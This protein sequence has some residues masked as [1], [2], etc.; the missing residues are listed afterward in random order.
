[1]TENH[2][3]DINGD[4]I[5]IQQNKRL[6]WLDICL[7]VCPMWTIKKIKR[8]CC[9][10]FVMILVI[11]IVNVGSFVYNFYRNYQHY[12]NVLFTIW[13]YAEGFMIVITSMVTLY[14]YVFVYKKY[15]DIEYIRKFQELNVVSVNGFRYNCVYC[16]VTVFL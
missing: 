6:I 10:D 15:Y 1:M 14:Y 12:G 2:L 5:N 3:L 11:I 8:C 4:T 13:Y 7:N 9:M 16:E